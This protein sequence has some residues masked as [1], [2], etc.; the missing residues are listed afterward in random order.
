M[1]DTIISRL[2]VFGESIVVLLTGKPLNKPKCLT[3]YI[4]AVCGWIWMKTSGKFR[5]KSGEEDNR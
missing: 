3:G 2:G 5:R 1:G 4:S